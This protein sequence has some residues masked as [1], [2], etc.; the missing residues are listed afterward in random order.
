[1]FTKNK[2]APVPIRTIEIVCNPCDKCER[3]KRLITETI[4]NIELENKTKI[5]YEFKHTP[6][7]QGITQYSI[8][9]SQT[10]AIIINGNVELSG[11]FENVALKNRLLAL[12]RTG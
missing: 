3:A 9:A 5:L 12:T 1:V 6:T 7:L 10:P 8:N 2:G 4:K 11:R